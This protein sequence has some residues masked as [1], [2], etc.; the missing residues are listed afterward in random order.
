[1]T[2]GM[3]DGGLAYLNEDRLKA[4]CGTNAEVLRK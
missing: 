2:S 4:Y 3:D 1:L